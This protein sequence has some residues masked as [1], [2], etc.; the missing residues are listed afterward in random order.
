MLSKPDI[1]LLALSY[2]L[3]IERNGGDWRIRKDP[4]QRGLNGKPPAKF[5]PTA[6][7]ETQGDEVEQKLQNL[8]IGEDGVQDS[9]EDKTQEPAPEDVPQEQNPYE[10]VT[11][12][13]TQ[14]ETTEGD[15]QDQETQQ[16]VADNA[17]PEVTVDDEDDDSDGWI[18]PS[19]LK[20]H[21]AKDS[22]VSGS[23]EAIQET[24]Q[25]A[26]LTSD[27]A[28]QNVALRINLKYV[29]LPLYL[30]LGLKGFH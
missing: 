18:T 26:L 12:E 3:E 2:E 21:Q 5:D 25:A 7:K 22:Q 10:E 11:D 8:T 13:A 20:K 17:A 16:T 28:M 27:F 15:I 30:F 14:D 9:V 19:N 23:S 29:H 1:H 24:L 4:S 6:E